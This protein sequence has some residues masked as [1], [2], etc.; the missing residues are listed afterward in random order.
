MMVSEFSAFFY[1]NSRKKELKLER[2]SSLT[3]KEFLFFYCFTNILRALFWPQD[4]DDSFLEKQ[5]KTKILYDRHQ[6]NLFVTNIV[7]GKM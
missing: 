2:N 6:P 1:D 3:V 7:L 5:K 4:K